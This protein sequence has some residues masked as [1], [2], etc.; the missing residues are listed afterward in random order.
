MAA[1]AISVGTI[2][3][4]SPG[5]DDGGNKQ[6]AKNKKPEKK[7]ETRPASDASAPVGAPGIPEAPR[8][9]A[10]SMTDDLR[11][12]P[13][14]IVVSEGETIRFLLDNPTAAPHDFLI[15][16]ADE[17]AHHAEEMTGG[18]GHDDSV[19]EAG[20]LPGAVTLEPGESAEVIATFD[21]AGDLLI[22][23]H[24]PGHWEAGMRGAIAVLPGQ[25][26][27]QVL[28]RAANG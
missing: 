25:D 12:D 5:H 28:A 23:C 14:T 1:G 11:F 21:E 24:V 27:M 13:S 22:G 10:I 8:D 26:V 16:D 17:Q 4:A 3:S 20:G 6:G 19:V 15:G 9:V 18:M 2:A 7:R